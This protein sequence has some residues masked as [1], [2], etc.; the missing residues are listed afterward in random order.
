[1]NVEGIQIKETE[2]GMIIA[3]EGDLYKKIAQEWERG[4]IKPFYSHLK[5]FVKNI[6]TDYAI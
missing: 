4:N 2:N 3:L 6:Q 1:L 5:L